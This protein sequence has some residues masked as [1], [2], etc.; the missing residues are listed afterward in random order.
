MS[1]PLEGIRLLEW[2]SFINWPGAGYML[3]DLGAEVVKIEQPGVGDPARG[4]QRLWDR[5]MM[6]PHGLNL[7]FET[8]NRNKR[9]VNPVPYGF[10]LLQPVGNVDDA[11]PPLS[12]L[13]GHS[14]TGSRS[15]C[16]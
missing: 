9:G 15:P 5:Q 3:G 2:A 1:R 6:L 16:R 7:V 8:F 12:K 11:G 10:Q 13:A 14:R 4:S